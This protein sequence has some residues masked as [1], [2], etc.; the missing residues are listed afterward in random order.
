[1]AIK[2]VNNRGGVLGRNL[3]L[4][5]RDHRGNPVRGK[6][7]IAEFS[8]MK[9]L[10]AVLGGIH[11]P[12][13]LYELK[14]IHKNKLIYLGPWAAGTPIVK[15]GFMPNY[16]FRVSVR[17]AFA[18]GFLVNYALKLGYKKLGLLFERTG[19]GRSNERA[20]KTAL[21]KLGMKP[22]GIEWFGWGIGSLSDEIK[23]LSNQGADAVILV[24][25]PKEGG[26]AVK[27]MA[28]RPTNKQ[29][30]IISHWGISGGDFFKDNRENL[31]KI[32]FSFL[33]TFSFLKPPFPDRA[34]RFFQAYKS[35]YTDIKRP[36]D[37]PSP[38]GAAHAHDL[39][40]LLAKAI[41]Q[42]GTTDR[43]N[44]RDALEKIKSYSG[45][46]KDY[47]PPFTATRHDALDASSFIMT[48]YDEN[49]V[50]RPVETN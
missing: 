26:I 5:V 45:L 37:V 13:A 2:D 3:K 40:H 22:A 18:G 21:L 8:G 9:N 29:L 24:A 35:A 39:I 20:V 15:N 49:G 42:A 7:N 44:V 32:E 11:T 14:D 25:N 48:R 36:E 6:D 31:K 12:V 1:L 33:Q 28:T 23:R 41:T 30:P 46:M 43:S 47:A 34:N 27:S 17:D 38:V 4:V 16:V 19:W 10:V 50:I